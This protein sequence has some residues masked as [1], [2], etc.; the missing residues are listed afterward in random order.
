MPGMKAWALIPVILFCA[1][2]WLHLPPDGQKPGKQGKQPQGKATT[3]NRAPQESEVPLPPPGAEPLMPVLEPVRS[4][5]ERRDLLQRFA[6][7]HRLSGFYRLKSMVQSG[8]AIVLNSRGY[9][10][11]GQR[12]MTLQLYAPASHASR[13]HIQS[14]VRTF[15]VADD[16]LIMRTL[17][18]HRN[19]DNGDITLDK[20]GEIV[21]HKVTLIGS[22]LRM[23]AGVDSYIEFERIE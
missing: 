8:G 19:Q 22:A 9:L 15:T 2:P 23:Y 17:V 13:V 14:A 21:Q 1:P 20:P 4:A 18:G 16:Q 7:R 12:H 5:V 11:I 10:F 3:P 6:G